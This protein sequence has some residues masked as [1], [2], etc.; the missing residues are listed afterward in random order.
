[1]LAIGTCHTP[2]NLEIGSRTVISSPV[3]VI[4]AN[5]ERRNLPSIPLVARNDITEDADDLARCFHHT[6]DPQGKRRPV[7]GKLMLA[8]SENDLNFIVGSHP[9][10]CSY[11]GN[12]WHTLF[13]RTFWLRHA[14]PMSQGKQQGENPRC[15]KPMVK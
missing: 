14:G 9:D 6:C 7:V 2:A 4:Q 13:S 12:R 1:M 3:R 11:L 10:F 5:E 15:L 8:R